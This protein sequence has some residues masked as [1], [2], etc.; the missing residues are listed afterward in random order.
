MKKIRT[1]RLIIGL[2]L[3]INVGLLITLILGHP[4]PTRGGT[5]REEAVIQRAFDFDESQMRGFR[6]SRDAHLQGHRTLLEQLEQ[7]GMAFYLGTDSGD[8]RR[9]L[10]AILW[11]TEQ[12]YQVNDQHFSDIRSLCRPEQ[13][14]H[15]EEFVRSV[16]QKT[17]RRGPQKSK[18]R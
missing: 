10:D 5:S 6:D 12:I 8:K 17:A 13:V 16:L 7:Q 4:R 18:K 3:V 11:T 9:Q 14:G 1:L 2:L 15:L